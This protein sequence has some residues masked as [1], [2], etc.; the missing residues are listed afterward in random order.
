MECEKIE[1]SAE[2]L[3]NVTNILRATLIEKLFPILHVNGISDILDDAWDRHIEGVFNY[4]VYTHGSLLETIGKL[5]IELYNER[6]T[7]LIGE[8][9]RT[10]V[11]NPTTTL[12]EEHHLELLEETKIS[13]IEAVETNKDDIDK[14]LKEFLREVREKVYPK[15]EGVVHVVSCENDVFARVIT[16][17]LTTTYNHDTVNNYSFSPIGSSCKSGA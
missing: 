5:S 13:L 8:L 2:P 10:L 3:I 12:P 16:V 11:N 6:I 17:F 1:L 15:I 9:K 4:L 7:L 14:E